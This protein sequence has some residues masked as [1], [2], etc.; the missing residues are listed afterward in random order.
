[1][2]ARFVIIPNPKAIPKYLST[3]QCDK[4]IVG[5]SPN[6][7]LYNKGSKCS[8]ALGNNIGES[9]KHDVKSDKQRAERRNDYDVTYLRH[10]VKTT[11]S[12]WESGW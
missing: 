9:Q 11:L 2:A 4:Y 7:I 8:T 5:Y 12:C 3:R 10:T 6:G 1:M